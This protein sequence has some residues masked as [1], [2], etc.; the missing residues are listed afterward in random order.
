MGLSN[1]N[2]NSRTFVNVS[3]GK[4]FIKDRNTGEKVEY[5]QLTGVIT[6]MKFVDKE[7][8]NKPYLALVV[9]IEDIDDTLL[10]EISVSSGYFRSFIAAIR[11]ADLNK[12]VQLNANVQEKD[13][14]KKSHT[15]F[16]RQ[17]D[18]A[19]KWYFTKDDKK[20]VPEIE[21]IEVKGKI[22]AYDDEAFIKY[23]KDWVNSL[24]FSTTAKSSTPKATPKAKEVQNEEPEPIG[25][26][27][28]D[29]DD[30]PF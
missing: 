24:H 21:P 12:E 8:Q 11:N 28:G 26:S 6:N 16:V 10:L 27:V 22:V 23:W 29:S 20:D 5:S 9:T 17:N 7:Y 30:L 15:I 25:R 19:I 18:A 14:G 2:S 4:F 1:S 3:N 13:N